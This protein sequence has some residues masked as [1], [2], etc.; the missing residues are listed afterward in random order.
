MNK[1]TFAIIIICASFALIGILIIQVYWMRNA[2]KLQAELFDN[3]VSVTLKSVVNRMFDEKAIEGNGGYICTHNCDHRTKQILEAI[4]PDR[5]DSLMHE[6]FT[7]MEITR[8]YVWGVFDPATGNFFAGEN[9]NLKKEILNSNHQV[10]LSCLY[11]TEQLLLGVYFPQESRILLLRLVPWILLSLVFLVI[12]VFAFTYMIFSFMK[13][14]KLSELK[15]DFVNNMT[16]ELKTPISTIS[17]ASEMLLSPGNNG[18]DEKTKKYA[19]MIYDENQRLQQQVERVLQMAVLEEGS[20]QLDFTTFDAHKL[21]QSCILR[22]ELL[23]KS[24]DGYIAF[25]RQAEK[26]L[27]N[28]DQVHLQNI[29]CNLIDNAVKYSYGKPEITIK[30]RN[31]NDSLI[32][33]VSDNGTGISQEDQKLIF[34]KL[35]RVPKGDLHDVKGFG[36]GLYYVKTMTLALK[37][38]ILVNSTP[39]NGSTFEI[40]IPINMMEEAYEQ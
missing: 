35:Y 9:N 31:S 40:I 10:S 5:L 38:K 24:S 18:M 11:R 12:L 6:E 17:L 27:I 3:S 29:I 4:N 16:H 1:R 7:G 19:R 28:S 20:F 37:G 34:D 26:Y 14:K 36:L 32:I 21:I 2:Y 23:V 15:S 30:T 39:G 33:S 25:E 13:Q 22:F 8:Q